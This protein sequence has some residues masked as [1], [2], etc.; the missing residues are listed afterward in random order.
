MIAKTNQE[1]SPY[2]KEIKKQNLTV[3]E[4]ITLAS[5]I[6]VNHVGKIDRQ[7]MA[8]VL[9]NR[10]NSNLPLDVKSAIKYANGKS[11]VQVLTKKDYN[12]TS[13]YNLYQYTGMGPGPISNPTI[14]SLVAVLHPRDMVKSYFAYSVNTSNKKVKYYNT[15]VSTNLLFDN[16]SVMR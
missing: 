1:V 6:E 7:K 10:L 9:Y 4:A 13:A 14:K 2:Y 3:D 11:S 8:G 5:F 16:D 15:D 12:S